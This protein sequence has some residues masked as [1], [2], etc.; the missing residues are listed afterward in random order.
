MA[1]TKDRVTLQFRIDIGAIAVS[2]LV[3]KICNK[4]LI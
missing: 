2:Q 1:R 3:I 4:D